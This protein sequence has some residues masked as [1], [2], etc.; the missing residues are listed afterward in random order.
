MVEM[1]AKFENG[2]IGVAPRAFA[3]LTVLSPLS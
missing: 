3:D 2:L 1:E